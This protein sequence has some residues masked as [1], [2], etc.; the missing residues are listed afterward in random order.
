MVCVMSGGASVYTVRAVTRPITIHDLAEFAGVSVRTV[1]WYFEVGI[2]PPR[3]GTRRHPIYGPEHFAALKAYREDIP[4]R[5][6]RVT[7]ACIAERHGFRPA[8]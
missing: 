2:L 1:R 3:R 8:P 5:G 7:A 6:E 4:A